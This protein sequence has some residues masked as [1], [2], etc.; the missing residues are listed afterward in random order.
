VSYTYGKLSAMTRGFRGGER[1]ARAVERLIERDGNRCW[2]CGFTFTDRGDRACTIDHVVPRSRG[3]LNAL[4]NVRLACFCCNMR[5]GASSVD[6][7]ER[8]AALAARRRLA[9]RAE[10]LDSG[11]WL[12][13]RAFHHAAIRWLGE[14]RWECADCGQGSDGGHRSPATVPCAPWSR[15]TGVPWVVWWRERCDPPDD[16]P[17]GARTG[18]EVV[19]AR[20]PAPDPFVPP[21]PFAHAR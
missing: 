10:M 7:Y 18:V 20:A 11:R 15:E 17:N 1:R 19:A 9:Y 16:W 2:Y 5:R 21:Y 3:G 8:S 12:P 13:K 4:G 6:E 14:R